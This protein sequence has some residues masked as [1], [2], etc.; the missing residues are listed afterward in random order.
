MI[1]F[2]KCS[3]K[4]NSKYTGNQSNQMFCATFSTDFI[5]RESNCSNNAS[6]FYNNGVNNFVNAFWSQNSTAKHLFYIFRLILQ[7]L[8]TSLPLKLL[9]SLSYLNPICPSY[10]YKNNISFLSLYD[11]PT[12]CKFQ[13]IHSNY[14]LTIKHYFKSKDVKHNTARENYKETATITDISLADGW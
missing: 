5:H 10:C 8:S 14:I 4:R 3:L 12:F 9:F 2:Y 13:L 6:R 11:T 1:Q 7:P